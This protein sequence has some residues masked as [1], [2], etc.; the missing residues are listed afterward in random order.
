MT[1]RMTVGSQF[2]KAAIENHFDVVVE[3]LEYWMMC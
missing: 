2:Q 1:I 3:E